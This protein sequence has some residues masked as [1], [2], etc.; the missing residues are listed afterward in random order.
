MTQGRSELL[1]AWLLSAVVT[2][3]LLSL[4]VVPTV[5][6]F[7]HVLHG[8]IGNHYDDVARG[9][10]SYLEPGAPISSLGFGWIF[11]PLEPIFG[12]RRAYMLVLAVVALALSWSARAVIRAIAG[13]PTPIGLLGFSFAFAWP[14]YMGFLPFCIAGAIGLSAVAI[15]MSARRRTALHYVLLGALLLLSALSHVLPAALCGLASL[16]LATASYDGDRRREALRVVACGVPAGLVALLALDAG[17]Q[18][19]ESTGQAASSYYW[20]PWFTRLADVGRTSVGGP[21]WRWLPIVALAL[22]GAAG[23]ATSKASPPTRAA[24]LIGTLFVAFSL[25]APLHMTSWEY[26]APRTLIFGLVLMLGALA[27]RFTSEHQRAALAAAG[28]LALSSVVWGQIHNGALARAGQQA[29]AGADGD[30]SRDGWRFP[31][32]F[33]VYGDGVDPSA[34]AYAKPLTNFAL[35]Y[36]AEQGGANPYLFASSP[37][38]HPFVFREG[39]GGIGVPDRS[40]YDALQNDEWRDDGRLDALR[41][42]L[43]RTASDYQDVIA[44]GDD[45]TLSLMERRGFEFDHREDRLGIARFTGCQFHVT[46]PYVDGAEGVLQ[47][48]WFPLQ[49]EA[50]RAPLERIG[51]S[52]GAIVTL[53]CG[54]TW[55]RVAIRGA[56]STLICRGAHDDGRFVLDISDDMEFH[57]ELRPYSEAH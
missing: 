48:G 56:D 16:G 25:V 35:A 2:L 26:F 12:W 44:F 4:D 46:T 17:G 21:I 18:T 32:V 52:L 36:A 38:V 54:D 57:C 20:Q 14:L 1:L 29:L 40:Y 8:V 37:S 47:W 3:P 43:L 27:A 53:P 19:V 34:M 33:D 28:A 13:R 6:G 50:G 10:Q 7:H 45:D 24:G 22:A 51:D 41:T 31:I 5:D 15:S 49:E 55:L 30:I 42:S 39:L 11:A 23:A 9:Y